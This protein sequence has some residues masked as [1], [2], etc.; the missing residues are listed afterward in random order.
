MRSAQLVTLLVGVALLPACGT[1]PIVPA[2]S[3][4]AGDGTLAEALE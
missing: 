3:G 2:V 4:S 1:D